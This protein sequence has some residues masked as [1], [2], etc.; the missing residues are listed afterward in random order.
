[1][2]AIIVS[3]RIKKDH[4]YIDVSE[5][6]VIITIT[7]TYQAFQRSLYMNGAAINAPIQIKHH[8]YTARLN[9]DEDM[10]VYPEI[11]VIAFVCP[12][13]NDVIFLNI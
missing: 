4:I 9:I 13:E 5:G 1:M 6:T 12:V 7:P 3:G 2:F 10:P 11:T 8:R